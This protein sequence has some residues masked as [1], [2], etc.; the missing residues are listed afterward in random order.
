MGSNN[1]LRAQYLIIG[2][3]GKA[4]DPLMTASIFHYLDQNKPFKLTADVSQNGLGAS[5]LQHKS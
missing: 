5:L 4:K 3:V 2:T 1:T